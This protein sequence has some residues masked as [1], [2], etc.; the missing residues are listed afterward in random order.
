[1][2]CCIQVTPTWT[3][4]T[5]TKP[6]SCGWLDFKW[7]LFKFLRD[8]IQGILTFAFVVEIKVEIKYSKNIN[9]LFHQNC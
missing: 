8:Q 1:M 5:S 9:V 3:Y 2:D 7:Y 4:S 6:T